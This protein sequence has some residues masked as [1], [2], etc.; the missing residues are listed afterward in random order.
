MARFGGPFVIN[1]AVTAAAIVSKGRRAARIL[2]LPGPAN[3]RCRSASV[4]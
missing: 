4:V 2:P 3:R 1:A